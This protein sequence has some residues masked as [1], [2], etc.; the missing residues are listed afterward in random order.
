M[1]YTRIHYLSKNVHENCRL[2]IDLLVKW[3]F[4]FIAIGKYFSFRLELFSNFKIKYLYKRKS[5]LIL[6]TVY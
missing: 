2:L 5:I 4:K 6:L 1:T 3:A